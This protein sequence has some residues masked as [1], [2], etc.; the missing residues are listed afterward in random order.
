[1]GAWAQGSDGS[2][3]VTHYFERVGGARRAELA[4]RLAVLADA[5]GE[6]RYTVR[7]PGRVHAAVWGAGTAPRLTA[8]RTVRT[9]TR[10]RSARNPAAGL[11]LGEAVQET[12]FGLVARGG[13]PRQR[14]AA[15]L[16]ERDDVAAAVARVRLPRDQALVLEPVEQGHHRRAV[17]PET[18]GSLLLGLGLSPVEEH[19]HRRARGR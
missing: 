19:Q 1:M 6:T 5:V 15:R 2:M 7:F 14:P 3:L 4:E 9:A 12:S 8:R 18:V 13:R 11:P 10:P 16:G 17:D